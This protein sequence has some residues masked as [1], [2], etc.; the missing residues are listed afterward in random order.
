MR[1][2]LKHGA[3]VQHCN[4]NGYSVHN[5]ISYTDYDSSHAI[6]TVLWCHDTFEEGQQDFGCTANQCGIYVWY[7][8]SVG[9]LYSV[10][11]QLKTGKYLESPDSEME[12]ITDDI[13]IDAPNAFCGLIRSCRNPFKALI[14]LSG[15]PPELV[16]LIIQYLGALGN[17]I[18]TE[19]V[20]THNLLTLQPLEHSEKMFWAMMMGIDLR[21]VLPPEPKYG[22]WVD[23]DERYGVA[24]R[25]TLYKRLKYILVTKWTPLD[26]IS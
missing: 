17:P 23:Q 22:G 4:T 16:T 14:D 11:R 21:R 5:T 10:A 8:D 12:P 20:F 26:Q 3:N 24:V 19:D 2:L 25:V 7:L 18:G 1:A 6:E 9:V 15:L 13:L